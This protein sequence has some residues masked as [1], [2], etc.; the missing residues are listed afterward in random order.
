MLADIPR[1]AYRPEIEG[2]SEDILPYYRDLVPRLPLGARFVEV[3]VAHG[4][5][6]F[7]LAEELATA[8]RLDVELHAV[9]FWPGELFSRMILPQ[10]QRQDLAHLVSRI[11]WHRTDGVRAAKLFEA[12]SLDVV[13]IDSDHTEAGMLAHLDAWGPRVKHGGII[14]G[15][16][17]HAQDWPGVVAAVDARFNGRVKRPTR[18]VWEVVYPDH[19]DHG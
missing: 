7:F 15:H 8:G 5:S 3:G 16:D 12:Y 1:E 6:L 11:M 19:G 17:Y 18:T 10:L 4:R 9:D 13:F 14:A 2:W